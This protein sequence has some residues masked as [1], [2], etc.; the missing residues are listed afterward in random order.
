MISIQIQNEFV[1]V[2]VAFLRI[3]FLPQNR[4]GLTH[5]C[6]RLLFDRKYA[7]NVLAKPAKWTAQNC[8]IHINNE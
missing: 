8:M 5:D 1:I 7:E 4:Y 6:F 3:C 2:A